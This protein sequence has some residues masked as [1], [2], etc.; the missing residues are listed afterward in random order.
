MEAE[1]STTLPVNE[2]V[3]V[4]FGYLLIHSFPFLFF[5]FFFWENYVIFVWVLLHDA[6]SVKKKS[7]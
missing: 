4:W 7:S 1:V 3:C 5:F 2:R 6:V